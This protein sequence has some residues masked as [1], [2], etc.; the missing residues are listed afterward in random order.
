MAPLV[1]IKNMDKKAKP[2]DF[3]GWFE[4]FNILTHRDYFSQFINCEKGENVEKGQ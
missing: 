2:L 1:R 3:K 4:T